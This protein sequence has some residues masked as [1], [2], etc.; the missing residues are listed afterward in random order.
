MDARFWRDV[1]LSSLPQSR[2][3]ASFFLPVLSSQGSGRDRPGPPPQKEELAPA[4]LGR[5]E[6]TKYEYEP[7][8]LDDLKSDHSISDSIGGSDNSDDEDLT[9]ENEEGKR[10]RR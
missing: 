5:S 2:D 9:S 7:E 8:D 6:E 10:G 4:R 1:L 3:T